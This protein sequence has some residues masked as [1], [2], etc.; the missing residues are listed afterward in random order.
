MSVKGD[1][2]PLAAYKGIDSDFYGRT[3]EGDRMAGPFADL[4]TGPESRKVD[5]RQ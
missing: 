5:P 3:V 1:M 4:T 2:K